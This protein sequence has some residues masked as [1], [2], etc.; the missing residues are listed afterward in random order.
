MSSV[1][2]DGEIIIPSPSVK[3]N[4][5]QCEAFCMVSIKVI[6]NDTTI[7]LAYGSGVCKPVIVSNFL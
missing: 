1:I 3:I 6:V 4:P 5:T 2:G 7:S